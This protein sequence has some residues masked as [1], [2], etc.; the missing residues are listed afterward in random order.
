MLK[1]PILF[2]SYIKRRVFLKKGLI[3][4]QAFKKQPFAAFALFINYTIFKKNTLH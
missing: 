2:R 3:K 1:T 4:K